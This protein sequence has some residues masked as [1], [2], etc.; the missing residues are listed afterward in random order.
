MIGTHER[1]SPVVPNLQDLHG[2]EKQQNNREESPGGPNI[3]VTEAK[4]LEPDQ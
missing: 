3:D 1:V 4:D 2:T